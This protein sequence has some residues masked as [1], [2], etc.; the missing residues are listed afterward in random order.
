MR[1]VGKSIGVMGIAFV[2][3]L[4]PAIAAAQSTGLEDMVGARAGQAEA[5]L[6]RRGYQ[7]VRGEQGDDRSYTYWWNAQ[8]RQCVSIATSS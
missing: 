4:L 6:Q 5:E 7:N 1:F 8:R 2:A 3:A